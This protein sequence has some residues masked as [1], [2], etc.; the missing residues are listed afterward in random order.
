MRGWKRGTVARLWQRQPVLL[1]DKTVIRRFLSA[2]RTLANA[3]GPSIVC[4]DCGGPRVYEVFI[5]TR[6]R[7]S[8]D[9]PPCCCDPEELRDTHGMAARGI[10]SLAH[11]ELAGIDLEGE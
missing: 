11:H 10:L 4:E 6:G 3:V 5:A 1:D 2:V 9:T 8:L 7:W